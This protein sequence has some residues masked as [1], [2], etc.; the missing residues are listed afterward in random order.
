[1]EN[2]ECSDQMNETI[3]LE[4]RI[5]RII[6][7]IKEKRSRPCYQNILTFINRGSSEEILEMEELIVILNSMLEKK[8][9]FNMGKKGKESFNVST[10]LTNESEENLDLLDVSTESLEKYINE[11]FYLTLINRI[12][13]E[14]KMAVNEHISSTNSADQPL[15]N[16]NNSA[17][18]DLNKILIDSLISEIDF[19]R[20]E[21]QSKDKLIEIIIKEKPIIKNTNDDININDFKLDNAQSNKK[22]TQMNKHVGNMNDL[23]LEKQ[24]GDDILKT[25]HNIGNISKHEPPTNLN[26]TK[27]KR[28]ITILGDSLIKNIK[29]FKMRQCM[30]INDNIHIKSFPG[31]SV[32]CM[33]DYVKP[34]TKFKPDT[35]ALHCGT[36]DL[37]S[38]KSSIE[39]AT[40]IINLAKEIKTNEND[41]IISSLV[42]RKDALN[43]KGIEVNNF[44]NVKCRENSFIFCD[45]S[46]I[47][48]DYL[49]ASGLHLKPTGTIALANNFL[50]CLKF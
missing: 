5:K 48:E 8:V 32:E 22:P 20:K 1:M 49:N 4:E 26:I 28:N 36:N 39:I 24:D 25:D 43:T 9:I 6:I 50:K 41:I 45:N 35:F 21:L 12:K 23:Y 37:R 10:E 3:K 14:V 27:K 30:D 44:L 16:G 19:L 46:N 18:N 31:A 40:N 17:T 38:E 13:S 11:E 47:S 29:S 15:K 2:F 42:T 7:K 34:S 33:I